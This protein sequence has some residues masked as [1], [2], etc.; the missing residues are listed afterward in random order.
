MVMFVMINLFYI[1]SCRYWNVEAKAHMFQWQCRNSNNT[2]SIDGS[3]VSN[4][5]TSG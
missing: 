3:V 5:V 2:E 1:D 4:P